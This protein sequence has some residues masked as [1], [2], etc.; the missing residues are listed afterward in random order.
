MFFLRFCFFTDHHRITGMVLT[1]IALLPSI[2]WF[3]SLS[4]PRPEVLEFLKMGQD[5]L[6]G[7]WTLEKILLTL[8]VPLTFVGLAL[9]FWYRR[10]QY[11]W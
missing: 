8:T 3:P 1:V 6:L 5:Y 9:M 7:A 10:W 11:D 4:Q 2:F